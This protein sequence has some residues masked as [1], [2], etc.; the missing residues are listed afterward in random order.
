MDFKELA[1]SL[2]TKSKS[3]SWLSMPK[4]AKYWGTSFSLSLMCLSIQSR[5]GTSSRTQNPNYYTWRLSASHSRF[6]NSRASSTTIRKKIR[7]SIRSLGSSLSQQGPKRP[8]PRDLKAL[9]Y[10]QVSLP[11]FLEVHYF[12]RV[13]GNLWLEVPWVRR[14]ERSRHWDWKLY[15]PSMTS[16]AAATPQLGQTRSS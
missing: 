2:P 1:K 15:R 12:E 4:P 3:L 13:M 14:S 6:S 8:Q 5:E 16:A 11:S 9:R 7:K 10:Y